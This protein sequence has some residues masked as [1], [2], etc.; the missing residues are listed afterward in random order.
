MELIKKSSTDQTIY[1]MLWDSSGSPVPALVYNSAG[2]SCYYVRERGLATDITLAT[3]A[4]AD[5]THADGGFKEVDATNFPG[6]YRLDLPDAVVAT[7]VSNVAVK[8]KFTATISSQKEIQ[9]LD[10]IDKDTYDI[11][12]NGTYGNAQL[13][14]SSALTTHDGKLDTVDSNVDLVLEDTAEMQPKLPTNNIMGSSVKTD[15]DDE[16]DAIK[17]KTDTIPA[18]PATETNVNANET[19]IDSLQ[20]D[21]TAVKAKTDNQPVGIVKNQIFNYFKFK[22]VNSTDNKTGETGLTITATRA[23]DN[24]TYS[25]CANSVAEVG[26]GVYRINFAAA[27]LNGD[28]IAFRFD[29]GV[30][31]NVRD[32]V[33][34]TQT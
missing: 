8:I 21:I 16:I 34:T 28:V 7:G 27:D 12:N 23:I 14:R 6:L 31:A 25:A 24:G 20:T 2:A 22:M 33:I 4:A 11:V 9:L 19:K 18:D 1:F 32:I 3:L 29:G 30:D 26:G 5:S 17:A 10:N 13:A 15:K